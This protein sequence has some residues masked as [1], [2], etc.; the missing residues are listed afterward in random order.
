MK[1]RLF[2]LVSILAAF[3]FG[4]LT[5]AAFFSQAVPYY[6]EEFY[7]DLA[8]GASGEQLASR[9]KYVLRSVHRAPAQGLTSGEY[10]Q[11][12]SSCQG[13]GCYR[14]VSLGYDSARV[15]LMGVYYLVQDGNSYGVQDVYCGKVRT[16]NEFGG[17][18]PG[19][20]RIPEGTVVNTEHTWPQSKFTGK[21]DTG[22]QKSDL[23]HL[24]PTDS[25]M[26]SDRSSNEFGDV[27]QDSK[28]L[29]CKIA[30]LGTSAKGRRNVFE[31]PQAH[32]GNVARAIFYFALR[33]DM[34]L[35]GEQEE[36][37]R[38]WHRDDPVDEDEARRND[39][40][41][42]VQGNRNPFIDHPELV[43]MINQF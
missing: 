16:S 21:F 13:T 1:F 43:D 31:A 17:N 3:A 26:N 35:G 15:F 27:V 5:Q 6:G 38:K 34:K 33:Y 22:M 8:I 2:S 4:E 39:E 9:L 11:I 37:L 41:M 14:H 20:R 36:T 12:S 19:P 18:G 30:R 25:Q 23:H 32:K 28:I 24:F 10:D 7:R 42:K 29:K 40:I